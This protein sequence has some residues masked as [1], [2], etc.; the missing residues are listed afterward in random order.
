MPKKLTRIVCNI[1]G[2][3]NCI[4]LKGTLNVIYDQV[5]G[6]MFLLP[7]CALALDMITSTS[8]TFISKFLLV[9]S[10]K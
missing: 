8:S 2:F 5:A 3:L 1:F 9:F 10:K 4:E 6:N 7:Y